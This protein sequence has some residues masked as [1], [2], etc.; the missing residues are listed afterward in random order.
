MILGGM[1]LSW[2]RRS[3]LL[4]I[5]SFWCAGL[6]CFVLYYGTNIFVR[7]LTKITPFMCLFIIFFLFEIWQRCAKFSL[8]SLRIGSG[9]AI[10]GCLG[11]VLLYTCARDG[12]MS[13]DDRRYTLDRASLL[14]IGRQNPHI[15]SVREWHRLI[16]EK[17]VPREEIIRQVLGHTRIPAYLKRRAELLDLENFYTDFTDGAFRLHLKSPAAAGAFWTGPASGRVG[18]RPR[19]GTGEMIFRFAYDRP[20]ESIEY[21]DRHVAW[22]R[23]DR[24][25]LSFSW[26]G[27]DWEVLYRDSRCYRP[28]S[29]G[30]CLTADREDEKAFYLKYDFQAGDPRRA[31]DDNRGA[32]LTE[33]SFALSFRQPSPGR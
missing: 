23:G 6:Y 21:A 9:L 24:V 30:T 26:H 15:P 28:I 29:F 16:S 4:I 18:I 10:L 3:W 8:K 7:H 25:A 20:I 2:Y 17:W 31:A 19:D 11:A 27:Q 22:T 13:R 33:M 12:R 5:G 32:A 14:Q 1:V